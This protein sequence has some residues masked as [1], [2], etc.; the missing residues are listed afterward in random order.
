M[1]TFKARRDKSKTNKVVANGVTINS[2]AGFN[3]SG[4]AQGTLTEGTV[5]AR[6]QQYLGE[7]DRRHLQ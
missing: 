4:P 1:Y 2:G 6:N 7:P 5:F 3:L